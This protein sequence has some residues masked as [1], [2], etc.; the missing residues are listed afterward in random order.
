VKNTLAYLLPP[1]VTKKKK[2]PNIDVQTFKTILNV[3]LTIGN[4][5]NGSQCKGFQ[6]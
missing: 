3:L 6:V 4:F 2:F 5:L 1:S